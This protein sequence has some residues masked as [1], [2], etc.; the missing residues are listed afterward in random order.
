MLLLLFLIQ[1]LT[2][3][4]KVLLIVSIIFQIRLPL[5]VTCT[6][7]Q[8]SYVVTEPALAYLLGGGH[9]VSGIIK[10]FSF[11]QLLLLSWLALNKSLLSE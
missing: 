6:S 8:H 10:G 7:L 5:F 4:T 3:N 11:W 1:K 9:W 2:A